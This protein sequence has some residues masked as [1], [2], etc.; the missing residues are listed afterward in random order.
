MAAAMLLFAA[1]LI[2]IL[3]KGSGKLRSKPM[4]FTARAILLAAC[5]IGAAVTLCAIASVW[6]SMFRKW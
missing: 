6:R 4:A 1:A 5:T 3:R 2:S